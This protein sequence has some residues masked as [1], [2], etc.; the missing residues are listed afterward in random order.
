MARRITLS[1]YRSKLQQAQ[2]KQRQNIQKLNNAIQQYNNKV[3]QYNAAR[4]QAIDAHNRKVRAHNAR[5]QAKQAERK[6]AI[7][8]YNRTARAYNARVRANRT[9]LQSAL[10]RLAQ[11]TNTVRYTV[12]YK[13]VST[14]STKYK[15]LDIADANPFLS[16]LAEQEATNSVTVLNDLLDDD[17]ANSQ[18]DDDELKNSLIANELAHISPDLDN[19]WHGAIYA[20]NPENPD[21]ARHFCTSTREIIT[22]ILDTKAPDEDVFARFPDCPTTDKGTPTRRA[23]IHYCLDRNDSVN[24]ELENFIDANIDNVVLLFNELNSGTHGP[25]GKYSLQQLVSIK[26]RVEDAIRFMCEIVRTDSF[27]S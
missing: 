26:I 21:A 16:D 22:E 1:Q 20:L 25:A 2:A 12:L 27:R 4:K 17:T 18:A 14:L 6:R 3:R 19:R 10:G 5:V 8:A 7:D 15:R 13:S 24:D 11:Q 23:K 9:R